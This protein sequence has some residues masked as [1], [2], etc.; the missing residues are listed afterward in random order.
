MHPDQHVL[1][2]RQ[3]AVEPQCLEGPADAEP[4]DSM[5]RAAGQFDG[6]RPTLGRRGQEADA[7]PLGWNVTGH[8]VDEGRLAGAIRP[9]QA[10]DRA[11]GQFKGD[12]VDS[13]DTAEMP[14]DVSELKQGAQQA[15][16]YP[17]PRTGEAIACAFIQR[18]RIRARPPRPTMPCGRKMMTRIRMMPFTTSRYAANC[19]TI[20]GSAVRKTAPTIGPKTFVVPPTTANVRI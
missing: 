10:K 18:G 3:I 6:P 7:A 11:F 17:P 20:S 5:R 13:L 14:P 4:G 2:D 9:D 12:A 1:D 16:P 19:R 8:E 15:P